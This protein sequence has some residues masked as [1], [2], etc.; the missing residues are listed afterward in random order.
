MRL[1]SKGSCNNS[2][3]KNNHTNKEAKKRDLYFCYIEELYIVTV[4]I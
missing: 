3:N 1:K 2:Q 4:I